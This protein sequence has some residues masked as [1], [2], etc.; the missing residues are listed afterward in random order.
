[1]DLDDGSAV[2]DSRLGISTLR[3]R[4]VAG[5]LSVARDCLTARSMMM[6]IS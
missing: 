5:C 2:V 1:M 4:F 6:V 3:S